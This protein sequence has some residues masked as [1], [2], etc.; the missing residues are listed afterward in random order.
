MIAEE[1]QAVGMV[2]GDQHLRRL[3]V[4]HGAPF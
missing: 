3:R 4:H 1:L 2:R